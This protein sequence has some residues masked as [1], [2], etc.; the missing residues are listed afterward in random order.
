MK[1]S[2]YF[3]L[4]IGFATAAVV[5]G[6]ATLVIAD[7]NKL[8]MQ[9]DVHQKDRPQPPV[10]TPGTPSTQD[11]VGTAPSDAIVLF[12]GTNKD[13]FHN[14]KGGE[15]GWKILEDGALSTVNRSTGGCVT[16]QAFGDIQLH[17]E[18]RTPESQAN[19]KG[20]GKGNSGI[21]L[22][23]KYEIQVLNNF[24]NETYPDGMAGSL[25]GQCPP[26][27]NPA[28]DINE[29]QTYD[30]IW[31]RPHFNE[32]GSVKTPA[33]VTIL[34][35][36]V[37]VQDNQEL[38]GPCVHKRRTAYKAHAD[39]LPISFQNHGEECHY[40]NIWV[41]ELPSRDNPRPYETK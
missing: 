26:M 35:N 15:L 30:I 33:Y 18:F 31:R 1:L 25:Y 24:N 36:G 9:W 23:G 22:M 37:V 11:K 12:D 34:Q 6:G 20:Q 3:G 32:D 38:L 10:V 8:Y 27:V 19:R 16:K 39:K 13:A 28:R 29:W 14:G 17:V 2:R 40:R 7:A 4:A 41:R 21:F 5:L